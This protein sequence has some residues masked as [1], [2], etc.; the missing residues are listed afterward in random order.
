[1][2]IEIP[3]KSIQRISEN[4][5]TPEVNVRAATSVATAIEGLGGAVSK[6]STAMLEQ[7]RDQDAQD[8]IMKSTQDYQLSYLEKDQEVRNNLDERG[9]DRDTGR[10]YREIM[11]EYSREKVDDLLKYSPNSKGANMF[12]ARVTPMQ[13]NQIMQA[14]LDEMKLERDYSIKGRKENA[15]NYAKQ[16]SSLA[17]NQVAMAEG[18]L[19][20]VESNAISGIGLEYDGVTGKQLLKYG[21]HELANNAAMSSLRSENIPEISKLLHGYIKTEAG[22]QAIAAA[23]IDPKLIESREPSRLEEH[24]TPVEKEKYLSSLLRLVESKK[25]DELNDLVARRTNLSNL[26]SDGNYDSTKHGREAFQLKKDVFNYRDKNGNPMKTMQAAEFFNTL[27]HE[28]LIGDFL[29]RNAF[30]SDQAFLEN[31]QAIGAIANKQTKQDLE[32]MYP[33][34]KGKAIENLVK[35]TAEES[36]GK[37]LSA[38][39]K[40]INKDPVSWNMAND[41]K[42]QKANR[43]INFVDE[44]NV[45][46][47]SGVIDD[48]LKKQ[49]SMGLRPENQYSLS[50]DQY[51][52]LKE[53]MTRALKIQDNGQTLMTTL[54]RHKSRMRPEQ[55]IALQHEMAEMDEDSGFMMQMMNDTSSEAAALPQQL[56]IRQAIARSMNPEIQQTIK[57]QLKVANGGKPIT[58]NQIMH[59]IRSVGVWNPFADDPGSQAVSL[60]KPTQFGISQPI[61][62][63]RRME[64][65]KK[66]VKDLIALEG[67]SLSEATK[68]AFEYV[69]SDIDMVSR[70][71]STV[72]VPKGTNNP[73]IVDDMIDRTSNYEAMAVG[74]KNGAEL[75]EAYPEVYGQITKGGGVSDEQAYNIFKQRM[76]PVWFSDKNGYGVELKQEHLFG[77]DATNTLSKPTT[78]PLKV[79]NPKTGQWDVFTL[80]HAD[81]PAFHSLVKKNPKGKGII[82]KSLDAFENLIRGPGRKPQ[83]VELGEPE[84]E[85]V[86]GDMEEAGDEFREYVFRDTQAP[87]SIRTSTGLSEEQLREFDKDP[88]LFEAIEDRINARE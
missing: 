85:E 84:V 3:T 55:W 61:M 25:V 26:A 36:L 56:K 43:S 44:A 23:G 28:V 2:A 17:S 67:K 16:I 68:E 37:I 59:E 12:K 21:G 49:K 70:G 88:L 41:P 42:S 66:I 58:D 33:H 10:S 1:M 8:Y 11:E 38:R 19:S 75:K 60:L 35:E 81:V 22:Q 20:Q 73:K 47:I 13:T 51:E 27:N 46:D 30:V 50:M 40:V 80:K 34:L 15:D 65:T 71:D 86:M 64:Y 78:M 83:S 77:I 7:R 69:F 57:E 45:H 72:V 52:Q 29:K 39:R 63:S 87:E 18:F 4:V 32:R 76:S 24:L 14:D 31:A 5:A 54:A 82:N 53:S 79:K 48:N 62:I 74:P 9:K 6:I